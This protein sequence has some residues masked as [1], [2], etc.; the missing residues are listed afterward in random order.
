MSSI[1][2]SATEKQTPE[3]FA[4]MLEELARPDAFPFAVSE[5]I[6]VIQTHASAVLLAG[7]FAYKL[8]K[9][10]SFGFFDYSTPSLRRH[11]CQEEVRLNMRLAPDVYL[12]IAPVL[13]TTDGRVRFG[14]A[15]PPEYV[16]EPGSHTN[17]GIIVDY[18]VVMTRLSDEAMLETRVREGTATPKLLAE[19]AEHMASFHASV[20]TS[21]HIASFGDL[22]VIRG[23]WEENFSQV[24]PYLGQVLDTAM[25]D[26]IA[27]SVRRFLQE[28]WRLFAYRKHTG[29]IRDCHGDLRL[30]HVYVLGRNADT[31][32]RLAVIDGI[33]FNERFRYGDV[34][35]EI[36]FLAME[37]EMMGRADLARAFVAAYAQ[38]SGDESLRELLP[39]YACYRAYVRGKVTAFQLDEPEIPEA[40]RKA[41]CQQA[42]ALF[43][44]AT[45][46]AGELNP[47]TLLLVGGVMGTGKS[48]LAAALQ[49]ELGWALC[50]SDTTRKRLA[51][52]QF[53]QPQAAEFGQGLYSQDWNIRTYRALLKEAEDAL[54]NGRSVLLDASFAR[55]ADR[56]AATQLAAAQGAQAIFI[57]CICPPEVALQR[58]ARRWATRVEGGPQASAEASRA[59]DGRP[60][61]YKRQMAIWEAFQAEQ[62]PGLA[63]LLVETGGALVISVEQALEALGIPRFAC[64]IAS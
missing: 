51:G 24:R 47:P 13:L 18:A 41:A 58:L 2:K 30:Q 53:N 3:E 60:D 25:Y 62:E 17:E 63:H 26:Q 20:P 8:K 7:D 21:E 23:N 31:S 12:G 4:A 56:Q 39:F 34:A 43:V 36:A 46:Y 57:E 16:P 61:L 6:Q 54:A 10:K 37:L 55:R 33:E 27:T 9:P 38:A 49:R 59:S 5:P 14:P 48:T 32:H 11:F 40:Q 64:W 45:H 22:A 28:R 35:G 19:V 44:L 50:S 29:R 15:L 1:E 42:Q 52:L